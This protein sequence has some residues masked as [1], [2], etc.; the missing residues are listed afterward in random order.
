MSRRRRRI[1]GAMG[2][3]KNFIFP[4]LQPIVP[5]AVMDLDAT[6]AASYGGSGQTFSNLV[7][8]PADGSAQTDYD[9]Y[10]GATSG[11]EGSDPIFL[12][13]AGSRSAE[14][15]LNGSGLFTIKNGN[16]ALISNAQKTT[17][18]NNISVWVV[19]YF[20]PRTVGS[21]GFSLFG[22]GGTDPLKHGIA[23]GNGQFGTSNL[24]VAVGSGAQGFN[25]T[26]GSIGSNDIYQNSYK[27]IGYTYNPS[28]K[29]VKVY[30][31]SNAVVT[32]TVGFYVST[33]NATDLF[34]F[35]AAGAGLNV[36]YAGTKFI[37]MGKSNS[38]LSDAEVVALRSM[39]STRHNRTY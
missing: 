19:G 14:F 13:I 35:G 23:F 38:I 33:V 20:P 8:T 15:T 25:G 29:E 11:A 5:S 39:Y 26:S 27:F 30:N 21:N 34:Q 31:G 28:T 2:G 36:A 24:P 17:G 10:L 22:S 18:G 1:L 16:T 12:G 7:A 37:A 3:N 6:N 9:Y 4:A 32:G